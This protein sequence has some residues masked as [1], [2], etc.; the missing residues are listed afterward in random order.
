MWNSFQRIEQQI[1]KGGEISPFL[2]LSPWGEVLN[3]H[4]YSYLQGLLKQYT[5][6][7]QSLFH[8]PD[9]GESLKIEIVKRFLESGNS[10][11]RFAFQIFF[12]EN[13]SRMTPQAQS[14][15][16][17]F[18][19]EPGEGNIVILTNASESWILE[20]ILS[21]VQLISISQATALS[22]SLLLG[23]RTNSFYYSMIESHAN[24]TSDEL[25][26]Y[27]FSGKYEKQEYIDFLKSLLVF[28]A[29]SSEENSLSLLPAERTRF[30]TELE[31]DMNGIMKH[32]LQGKYIADKW[33]M[34]LTS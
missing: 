23:E 28:I 11:P 2:F 29:S 12:I 1:Q 4:I 21:R 8:L 20:T 16:L 25:V 32:N 17:K 26:R 18:F 14:A 22:N 7:R 13:I 9:D 34:Q 10:R 24:K 19:E 5:I 33:I 3:A 6:D 30:L 15:C 27:F 31:E